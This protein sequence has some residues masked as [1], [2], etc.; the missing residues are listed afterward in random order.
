MNKRSITFVVVSIMLSI[1]IHTTDAQAAA[2]VFIDGEETTRSIAENTGSGVGIGS[3][4]SATD[5][6]SD[7]LTYTLSGPDAAS[8]SIAST[9]LVS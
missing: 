3:A 7:A 8:F 2:P 9:T 5:V 1:Y 6:D 4:V